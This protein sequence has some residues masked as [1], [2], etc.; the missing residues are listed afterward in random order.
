MHSPKM[1]CGPADLMHSLKPSSY[2]FLTFPSSYI[3]SGGSCGPADFIAFSQN[4][5]RTCGPYTFSQIILLLISNISLFLYRV[6]RIPK[7]SVR[8][9]DIL[10]SPLNTSLLYASADDTRINEDNLGECIS[11]PDLMYYPKSSSCFPFLLAGC[12]S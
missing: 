11:P 12:S 8:M 9:V 1:S 5:R 3:E 10:S 2:L 6:R 7:K 4:V